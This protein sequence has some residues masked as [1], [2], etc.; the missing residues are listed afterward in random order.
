MKLQTV[1]ISSAAT[2]ALMAGAPAQAQGYYISVFGGFATQDDNFQATLTGSY[3]VRT[4]AYK[5]IG[6]GTGTG[7]KKLYSATRTKSTTVRYG[8]AFDVDFEDGWVFGA[9]LGHGLANDVRGELE[10]AYRKFDNDDVRQVSATG[11][12]RIASYFHDQITPIYTKSGPLSGTFDVDMDGDLSA[13]SFMA[14]L[15]YDVDL[16]NTKLTPF[17]GGGVGAAHVALDVDGRASGS[18]LTNYSRTFYGTVSTRLDDSSWAFAYQ[19]GAGLAYEIFHGGALSV[20][21]RYFGTSE[22]DIDGFDQRVNGHNFLV[23]LSF[24]LN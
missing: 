16:G 13:W 1:L 17:I 9:A 21:Y 2:L 12:Y 23:G 20:Q 7:T 6:T 18:F 19:F 15:W 11:Y 14:N 24:P 3:K 8:A 10:V 4:Y 22:T 5:Y